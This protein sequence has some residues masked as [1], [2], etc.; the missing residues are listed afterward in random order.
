MHYFLLKP[1]QNVILSSHIPVFCF[2]SSCPHARILYRALLFMS[3]VLSET[4]HSHPLSTYHALCLILSNLY[5]LTYTSLWKEENRKLHYKAS[6]QNTF[7]MLNFYRPPNSPKRVN[8]CFNWLSLM[9]HKPYFP[10]CHI[11]TSTET[12]KSLNV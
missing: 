8:S 1:V 3:S 4:S 6:K 2:L 12:R 11:Q 10:Q 7:C 5:V 9:S